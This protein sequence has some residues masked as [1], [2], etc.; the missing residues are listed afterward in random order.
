MET[1]NIYPQ[2]SSRFDFPIQKPLKK[3]IRPIL[4]KRT[5]DI[6][7]SLT[8]LIIL[9]PL[10]LF[11]A[12]LIKLTSKGPIIYS[13]ERIGRG[14]LVFKCHKYRTMRC[15]AEMQLNQLLECNPELLK[16]WK[17]NRK[18]KKDPRVTKIGVYLRKTSLDELP[19]LWNVLKGDLSL[20]G[21][22]PVLKEELISHYKSKAEKILSVR[23]GITGLW[24]ISG[25]NH[26][27]YE[28]RI[29]LDEK[30]VEEQSLLLDLRILIKTIPVV[31]QGNG[32]Y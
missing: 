18:L 7:F 12:I 24:Q 5:F 1:H 9:S 17:N 13:Q 6:I 4:F 14:G 22:R 11:V 20:V 8:G 15:D 27:K 25:R 19:Q 29:F 28:K 26:L 3:D 30:Y 16:E 32:A 10:F 23:P 31:F 21:P 2:N